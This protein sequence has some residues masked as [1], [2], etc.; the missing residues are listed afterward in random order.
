MYIERELE[1]K[2]KRFLKTLE[3]VAI[4]G[5]RQAGKTT[6]LKKIFAELSDAAYLSFEDQE[7]LALFNKS[8]KDFYL[9]YAKDKKYLFIDEFQYAKQ[10]G[11]NLKFLFDTYKIKI[12]ISG[13][14]ALDLTKQAIKYLVGRIF[15]L[16]LYPFNFSEFLFAKDRPLHSRIF[17]PVRDKIKQNIFGK[18][19]KSAK[20]SPVVMEKLLKYYKEYAV[21]GGYP[22][23]VLAKTSE[24]KIEVLKNIFNIYFLRE[25]RDVLKLETDHELNQLIKL[26]SLQIGGTVSYNELGNAIN[27]D[28]KNLLKHLRILEKTFI[29]HQ[30][31]PYYRNKR[32]EITKTPKV[33]FYDPGFR[34]SIINNFQ[35]YDDR[36]DQGMINENFVASAF[37]NQGLDPK[38][39]RT[40]SSAEI[41]FVI[42]K[43]GGLYAFEVKTSLAGR[44]GSRSFYSFREKYSPDRIV[45]LSTNYYSEK[46]QNNILSVPLYFL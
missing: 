44:G 41:D 2:I 7:A 16:Q 36:T 3:I 42:E 9:L 29:I 26:L 25:I 18:T 46:P 39:W 33:Y 8:I 45:A 43:D 24:E 12:I 21:F 34:N 20:V 32:T 5:P 23:A 17:L 30:A 38:Y 13:S 4:I 15:I 14:S 27:L 11:K 31:L 40:K 6:L 37:I 35:K 1:D 19:I 22:R 28:Y 10:G